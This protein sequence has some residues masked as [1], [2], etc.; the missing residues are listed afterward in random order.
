LFGV[1]LMNE[2]CV[3]VGG[4]DRSGK[5]YMRFM[6]ESHP[7]FIFSKRTNMW[8]R[9]YK[10]FGSLDQGE[11][12]QRCLDAMAKNKHIQAL[13]PDF[14]QIR[15]D[16]QKGPWSYPRLFELIHTQYMARHKKNIW[17]D[18]TEFLERYAPQILQAYPG[19]KFIHLL[20]D[21]RDRYEAILNKS[22]KR[23][24]PGIATA[25]WLLSASLAKKTSL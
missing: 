5:T 6:L 9:Y 8:T 24:S 3:F 16:W 12:F 2:T 18:Q 14:G 19:A 1:I 17:G 23:H 10:K 21:P 7:D 20:R 13:E 22:V 4:L 11:N 25:R 15:A